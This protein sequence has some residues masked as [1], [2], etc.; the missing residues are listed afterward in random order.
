MIHT[1]LEWK[2]SAPEK[3]DDSQTESPVVLEAETGDDARS[4]TEEEP[5]ME[6]MEDD[7]DDDDL[8]GQDLEDVEGDFTED[9][10][11]DGTKMGCVKVIDNV[12]FDFEDTAEDIPSGRPFHPLLGLVIAPTRELA[13]QVK[14]HI[15]AVAQFTGKNLISSFEFEAFHCLL[16]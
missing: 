9:E 16:Y 10:N 12:E 2:K 13:V 15:D 11:D 3:D 4:V 1:I 14:H 5:N 6:A 7:D 8:A